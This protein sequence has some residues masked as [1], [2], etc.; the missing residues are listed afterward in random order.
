MGSIPHLETFGRA[1]YI[2]RGIV[3]LLLAYFA[4][5]T[6][7]GE[8]TTTVMER[9]HRMPLGTPLL[10]LLAAGLFS[11]G[12]FRFYSA[13]VDLNGKGSDAKG[14][15]G[16]T[17]PLLSGLAHFLL[18]A[19]AILI[20][21]DFSRGGDR[22]SDMASGAM[23][24]PG[25][26]L[27]VAAAGLVGL[28]AGFGNFRKAWTCKFME[29]LTPGTPQIAR[30]AGRAGYAARG[31]VFGL[32]G[33]QILSLAIGWGDRELGMEAALQQLRERDWLFPMV[34]VGLGAFGLFS[35]IMA[36]YSRI[37][38]DAPPARAGAG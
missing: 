27:L 9:L 35:L 38:G 30:A 26:W 34:A 10:F 14:L 7:G 19:I 23:N 3:Y 24:M 17:G 11:Y 1:G 13:W 16:R 28:A 18:A 4:W 8:A 37:R 25:G 5:T 31:V 6:G 15:F 20:A 12:L 29:N 2:A 21:A 33:W 36:G 22:Q 32:I